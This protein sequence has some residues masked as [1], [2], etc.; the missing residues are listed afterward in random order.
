[1]PD[2]TTQEFVINNYLTNTYG[3]DGRTVESAPGGPDV[4]QYNSDPNHWWVDTDR[5]GW[6]DYGTRDAGYGHW[7]V[8]DGFVWRD[9]K[10]NV[11]PT[12]REDPPGTGGEARFGTAEA[13]H[14]SVVDAA[15][16]HS[17]PGDEGWFF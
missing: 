13:D 6:I 11:V 9:Y 14:H 5:D 15:P 8:F 17:A 12:Q 7:D 2:V 10:G 4:Y 16:A 3:N 1:M